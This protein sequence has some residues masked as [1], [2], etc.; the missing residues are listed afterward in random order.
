[1]TLQLLVDV[2]VGKAVEQWLRDNGYDIV[3]V[4]D[5]DPSLADSVILERGLLAG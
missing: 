2:N 4:R 3:A 5:I 1:M